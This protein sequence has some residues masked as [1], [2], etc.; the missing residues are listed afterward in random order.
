MQELA[1]GLK[2]GGHLFKG[3]IILLVKDWYLFMCVHMH[4]GVCV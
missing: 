3:G 1:W 4:M 2:G